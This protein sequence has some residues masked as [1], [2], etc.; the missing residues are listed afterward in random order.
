VLG[1]DVSPGAWGEG[2]M[3]TRAALDGDAGRFARLYASVAKGWMPEALAVIAAVA[4]R[5]LAAGLDED[6]APSSRR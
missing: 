2:A 1:A 3:L 5:E 6:R 4:V